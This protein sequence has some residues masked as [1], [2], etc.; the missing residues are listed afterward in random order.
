MIAMR[1]CMTPVS[2]AAHALLQEA[3]DFGNAVYLS[4]RHRCVETGT[5]SIADVN[6]YLDQLNQATDRKVRVRVLARMIRRTTAVQ[7]KWLVRIILKQLK[8]GLYACAPNH[9][10]APC[11]PSR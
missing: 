9:A 4:L 8:T 1:S 10:R 5:L 3:G 7:Q 11:S 6:S 2:Y